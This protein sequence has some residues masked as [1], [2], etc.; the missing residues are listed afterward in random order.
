MHI[1]YTVHGQTVLFVAGFLLLGAATLLVDWRAKRAAKTSES[2]LGPLNGITERVPAPFRVW[3]FFLWAL[4]AGGIAIRIHNS[5]PI[6][7]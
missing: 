4:S 5:R 1:N 2:Y 3:Q 7:F 6:P